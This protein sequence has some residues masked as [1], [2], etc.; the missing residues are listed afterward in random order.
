M[1]LKGDR[2]MR[3]LILSPLASETCFDSM[4]QQQMLTL[5]FKTQGLKGIS[6]QQHGHLKRGPA[7]DVEEPRFQSKREIPIGSNSIKRFF[8]YVGVYNYKQA[9]S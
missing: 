6:K 8:I 5:L 9:A 2:Q 1:L 3:V 7:F 4:H